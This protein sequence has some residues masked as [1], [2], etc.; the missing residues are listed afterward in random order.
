MGKGSGPIKYWIAIIPK[1]AIII[2]YAGFVNRLL[3]LAL[4][5]SCNRLPFRTIVISRS[6]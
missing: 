2:E 3:L 1:G 5:A 4:K 6:F